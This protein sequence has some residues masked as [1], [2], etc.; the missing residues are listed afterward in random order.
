[1][2]VFLEYYFFRDF[3]AVNDFSTERNLL[4]TIGFVQSKEKS[5]F[6]VFQKLLSHYYTLNI[7]M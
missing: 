4:S 3:G 2:N 6:F 7:E 1:M 5:H